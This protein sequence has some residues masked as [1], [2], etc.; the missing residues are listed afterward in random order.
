MIFRS[1]VSISEFTRIAN[2]QYDPE[3]LKDGYAP[4][5]K[6]LFIP[7]NFTNARVNCLLINEE[8]KKLLCSEY[9]ARNDKELPVLTRYFSAPEIEKSDIQLPVAKYLDLILYSREQINKENAAMGKNSNSDA[10]WG[11]I[12]IK[13]QDVNFELPMQPI[14]MMRNA[15]GV[16]EGGSGIPLDRNQYMKAYEYWKDKAVIS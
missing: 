9:A 16:E 6:H 2:S 7:N 5:C 10:P 11:I 12:S 8:N 1:D 14:T 4:F 13:A 15:L 3:A